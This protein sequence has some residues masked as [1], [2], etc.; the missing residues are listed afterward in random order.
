MTIANGK[1][2]FSLRP[3]LARARPGR[4]LQ[5]EPELEQVHVKR[6]RL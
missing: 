5:L 3:A 1:A 4:E 2:H 6:S